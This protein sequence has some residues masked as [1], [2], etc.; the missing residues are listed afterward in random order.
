[1][2]ILEVGLPAAERQWPEAEITRAENPQQLSAHY[3]LIIC[4]HWLQTV[5]RFDVIDL[6]KHWHEHL[7]PNGELYVIVTD[8]KW[9]AESIDEE[10]DA[11]PQVMSA[12]FGSRGEEH[13]SAYTMSMLRDALNRAG[14]VTQDARTGPFTIG[15][16]EDT[17]I[18]RQLF[19]RATK[20]ELRPPERVVKD[21]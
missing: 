16:G 13:R 18:A 20:S 8:L 11:N 19:A 15:Q 10:W 21:V 3:D 6:L 5:S 14:Y 17:I 7:T 1:M 12:L 2:Q 9:I 4:T